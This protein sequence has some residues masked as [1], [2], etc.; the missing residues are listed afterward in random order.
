M[1]VTIVIHEHHVDIMDGNNNIIR[2]TIDFGRANAKEAIIAALKTG[3]NSCNEDG[4][5]CSSSITELV[6]LLVYSEED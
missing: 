2:H 3:E 1:S 6:E 4:I 5:V